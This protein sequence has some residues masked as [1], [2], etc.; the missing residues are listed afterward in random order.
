[1]S[2]WGELSTYPTAD[3]G[4]P[5][6]AYVL[7]SDTGARHSQAGSCQPAEEDGSEPGIFVARPKRGMALNFD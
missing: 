7:R 5:R 2:G 1:M 4:R 6:V 3:R